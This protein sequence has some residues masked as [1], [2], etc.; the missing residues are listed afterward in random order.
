MKSM[1]WI[2][3]TGRSPYSAMPIAVPPIPEVRLELHRPREVLDDLGL[4]AHPRR[5]SRQVE[6]GARARRLEFDR[7]L[8]GLERPLQIARVKQV[9]PEAV[10]SLRV[11]RIRLGHQA[12][13]TRGL[14]VVPLRAEACGGEGAGIAVDLALPLQERSDDGQGLLRAALFEQLMRPLHAGR[15]GGCG[16]GRRRSFLRQGAH[17]PRNATNASLSSCRWPGIVS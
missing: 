1:N 13:D 9:I 16:S 15:R 8:E 17:L 7:A 4:V 2:S 5:D 3:G 11:L 10:P 12:V 6:V 14:R